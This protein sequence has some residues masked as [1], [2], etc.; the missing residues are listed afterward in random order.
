MP[1]RRIPTRL[2]GPATRAMARAAGIGDEALRRR[3]VVRL[4]RDTYLPKAI[5]GDT[6]ARIGAVL[7][8]A[9][10]GAVLSHATAADLWGVAIPVQ[11]DDVRVHITVATGSAVRARADRSIHRSPLTPGEVTVRRGLP[12]TTAARTWRDLAAVLPEAA[13]LAV[14]DQLV[15]EHCTPDD[16]RRQLDLRPSGRGAARAREVL[17]LAD[18]RAGSPMESVLR[19]LVHVARLP[20]PVLQYEIHDAQGFAGRVDLAWPDRRVLVEFDGDGHRDR[21]VFVEDVR[22]QNRLVMAGWT[23][24]RFTSADVLGRPDAVVAAIRVALR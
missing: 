24:L 7:L 3:D 21:R 6:G 22:R 4:S 10:P 16:L 18:R 17:P 8:T 19:W 20:A 13:L 2:T 15:V 9:P 11:P 1:R 5:A 14:A 12:V 23:I